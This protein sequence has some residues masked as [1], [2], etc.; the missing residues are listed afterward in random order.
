MLPVCS[1]S[2][3]DADTHFDFLEAISEA[4][5]ELLWFLVG[6][7]IIHMVQKLRRKFTGKG[8]SATTQ[9]ARARFN[10]KV[11]APS[12]AEDAPCNLDLA[13]Y[14]LKLLAAGQ[15]VS[16]RQMGQ[17]FKADNS[18][19]Q[20]ALEEFRD[21]STALSHDAISLLLNLNAKQEDV[22][23]ARLVEDIAKTS[24]VTPSRTGYEFLLK[25]YASAGEPRAV[26]I[27]QASATGSEI[28]EGLCGKLL[29]RC[30]DSRHLSLT[31]EIDKY[32]SSRRP[33]SL[34]TYR[35]LSKAYA[36]CGQLNLACDLY[37]RVIEDGLTPDD[38]TCST[39]IRYAA[40]C[41]R[42]DFCWGLAPQAAPDA[43]TFMCLLRLAAAEKQAGKIRTLLEKIRA[44][45]ADVAH[46]GVYTC[47]MDSAA[48]AGDARLGIE[49][50]KTLPP[51]VTPNAKTFTVLVRCYC[52][53]G[54]VQGARDAMADAQRA[55]HV[56]ERPTYTMMVTT[57]VNQGD[58]REVWATI[59]DMDRRNIRLDEYAISF[60]MKA[61]SRR[62]MSPRDA[63]K[64]MSLL[65][66]KGLDIVGDSV[67]LNTALDACVC[68]NDQDRL[69][70][71]LEEFEASNLQPTV[72]TYGLIIKAYSTLGRLDRCKETWVNMVKR[73]GLQ[74]SSIALG[75]MMDAMVNGG[76]LDGAVMLFR[77][78]QD[79]VPPNTVIYSTLLK[80]FASAGQSES[81]W[82]MWQEMRS[83]GLPAN[84]VVYTTLIDSQA[85]VGNMDKAKDLLKE[86]EQQGFIPNIITYSAVIRG[87]GLKGEMEAALR[88]FGE[89]TERGI[90][91]D[92]VVMN[93]LLD[94]C[95]RHSHFDLADQLLKDMGTY[96]I[97]PSNFTLSIVIKM[98]GKRRRLDEAFAAVEEMPR[99]HGFSVDGKVGCC[100]ISACL[101]NK[102]PS[103][104]FEVLRMMKQWPHSKGYQGPDK[105]VYD[106]LVSGLARQ[107]CVRQ[108]LTVA[109]EALGIG[110]RAMGTKPPGLGE[111]TLCGLC[112]AVSRHGLSEELGRPLV[113]RLQSSGRSRE[114][115]VSM[116]T[117]GS[118][119]LR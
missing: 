107:G 113:S 11:P 97:R 35:T 112:K 110:D 102:A 71:V 17:L 27:F 70:W 111:D 64:L 38:Q 47:A 104:A 45:Q 93:T 67:V 13:R 63:R 48:D 91:P 58:F 109:E 89:M 95:V 98:W 117:L 66:R 18:P 119:V 69:A 74:P 50:F 2:R 12:A 76:C 29:C 88:R 54:H 68:F 14:M 73:D 85:R 7:V 52:A 118:P 33:A 10:D 8:V 19:M 36:A 103:R 34:A 28:S 87:H 94:G 86:M 90:E 31:K 59:Q 60:L 82:A 114:A 23:C 99:K 24:G 77:R 51:H 39:F 75:C 44:S 65:D 96:S 61:D 30:A 72:Q 21:A 79:E 25:V 22:V 41:G 4:S 116:R 9:A 53:E 84:L 42:A 43:N 5:A 80:G 100:L 49:V 57:A 15:K 46:I 32:I 1:W 92:A 108:A 78:Y 62:R 101:H 55:G 81:A 3:Q 40:Q 37:S 106:V 105:S 26:D 56:L 16:L 83:A 115:A 20:Q 6:F